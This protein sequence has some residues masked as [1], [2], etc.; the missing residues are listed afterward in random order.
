MTDYPKGIV[1]LQKNAV[2]SRIYRD[3]MS[4]FAGHVHVVTTDGKAGR[5]GATVIAACSVSDE[6]PT[7][8]VCLSRKSPANDLFKVNGNFALNTL[9][10]GHEA[11]AHA[12]SG[13]SGLS[14]EG[15]FTVGHW[16]TNVTGAPILDDAVAS[17]DCQI[18][19][20]QDVATHRV[21]FGKVTGLRIAD[22]LR[23]LIYHK[24]GYRVL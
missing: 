19:A 7:I 5:R 12:F 16:T 1:V 15:R 4:L 17:F 21:L 6:P 20:A 24:R 2:E 9:G 8:L 18:E 10:E 3:A 14:G 23:P 22:S 11:V 13:L